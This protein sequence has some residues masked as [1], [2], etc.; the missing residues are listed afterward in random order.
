M[1]LTPNRPIFQVKA[2]EDQL[3]SGPGRLKPI[4]AQLGELLGHLMHSANCHIIPAPAQAPD[5]PSP[6]MALA[7]L[8][9][10]SELFDTGPG[11]G[12]ASSLWTSPSVLRSGEAAR[13]L[14]AAGTP[15]ESMQ[16]FLALLADDV[17]GPLIYPLKWSP[18]RVAAPVAGD[19]GL[20]GPYLVLA[21]C[22]LTATGHA[23]LTGAYATAIYEARRPVPVGGGLVRDVL[24]A[25][26]HLQEVLDAYGTECRIERAYPF[27]AAG[28]VQLAL[29][30]ASHGD[31][32][33]RVRLAVHMSP[34]VQSL[35][36]GDSPPDFVVTPANWQDGT[37]MAWLVRTLGGAA[38]V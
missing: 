15:G 20:G 17:A 36:P 37:F 19:L 4:G 6:A 11:R 31:I 33:R 35:P 18:I 3:M 34:G 14:Q 27:I 29:S 24:C 30:I 1:V 22:E 9:R 25:L 23:T 5:P 16:G 38:A 32:L 28:D 7:A 21:L 2:A 26:V 8:R 10:A 13:Q 12:L